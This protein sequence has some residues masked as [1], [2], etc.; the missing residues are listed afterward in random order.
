VHAHERPF[1][2]AAHGLIRDPH[3]LRDLLQGVLDAISEPVAQLDHEALLRG[4]RALTC[5]AEEARIFS[6]L[7]WSSHVY[8]AV[9]HPNVP[10]TEQSAT[11]Q[12][13]RQ[14]NRVLGGLLMHVE[15][16]IALDGQALAEL[17]REAAKQGA[18]EAIT[19]VDLRSF[20]EWL[21]AEAAG[22][23]LGLSEAAVRALER[24]GQLKGHRSPQG[25]LRFRRSELDR[26]LGSES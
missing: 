12:V 20:D 26:W 3:Q 14:P 1:L 10:Q 6:E 17:V 11:P 13:F 23:Y 21:T 4:E 8:I 5:R 24:R 9:K 19:K 25:H 2:D 15:S 18:A 7:P 16:L 22:T